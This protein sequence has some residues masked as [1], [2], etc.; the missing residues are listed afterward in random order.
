MAY[1]FP[2]ARVAVMTRAPVVGE[3]KTRLIPVLGPEKTTALFRAML[4][5]LLNKLDDARLAPLDIWSTDARHEFFRAFHER[6]HISVQQQ[7]GGDLGERLY[8]VFAQMLAQS[9]YAVVVGSDIPAL[10]CED[11]SLAIEKLQAGVDAVFIPAEDGGYGLIG[12]KRVHRDLFAD[13]PWGGPQVMQATRN[14]LQGLGWSW[15]ELEPC[16]DLDTADDLLRL[17]QLKNLPAFITEILDSL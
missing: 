5:H 9:H 1:S 16:W 13:I 3:V 11:I 17:K 4:A 6:P 2:T 15:A 12:L 10:S 8:H 14:K 7:Q